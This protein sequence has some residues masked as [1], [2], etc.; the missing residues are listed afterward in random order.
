[1]KKLFLAVVLVFL[2][3]APWV[4]AQETAKHW[5][6]Q[7][8]LT[9]DDKIKDELSK[10]L[11]GELEMF[12]GVVVVD[13]SVGRAPD[14]ILD[15]MAVQEPLGRFALAASFIQPFNQEKNS[16]DFR[17]LMAS[18]WKGGMK[19]AEWN[20]FADYFKPYGVVV[21][22]ELLTERKS[23]MRQTCQT[24]AEDFAKAQLGWKPEAVKTPT[25]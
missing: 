6:V 21:V 23:K 20:A 12:D 14:Y 10:Y 25:E 1:M 22:H 17:K 11:K 3:A 8:K 5:V 2:G 15:A 7:I 18:H 4:R 24:L 16:D 13:K 9:A 19:D